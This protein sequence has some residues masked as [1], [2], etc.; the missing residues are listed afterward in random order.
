MAHCFLDR[1][2]ADARDK[3]CLP[4]EKYLFPRHNACTVAAVPQ[5]IAIFG[6]S[7]NPP[8]LHHRRLA[9]TLAR[10][11]DEV[12]VIPCGPRPD[13]EATNAVPAIFRAALCDITFGGMRRTP[14]TMT[15]SHADWL[16]ERSIH[17]SL[18]P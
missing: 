4:K 18:K 3:C 9:E 15:S 2:N 16:V 6:G 11:F 12:R 1:N 8:G 13:K 17:A 14:L 7:F 10:K 5:R